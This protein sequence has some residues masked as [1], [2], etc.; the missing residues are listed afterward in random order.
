MLIL[1]SPA[2]SLDYETFVK[3]AES[4]LPH[5][6]KETQELVL[7]LKKLKSADLEKMMGISKKLAELNFERFQK[8]SPKFDLKNSKQAL[9]VFNGDVY[10]PI[11]K[12][13]FKKADFDF[14]QKHLRILSGLYGILKPLD[15]MQAYRLEM[16]TD[17]R[18]TSLEKNLK[19]KNLYQFWGDK[20]SDF[21][22]SE[23]KEN[24]EKYIINLASEEYFSA[25]NPKKIS[26]KIINIIFKEKKAGVYKIIGINAKRARGLMVNFIIENK[27]D[28][29][30]KLKKFNLENYIFE[31]SMSDEFNFTFVR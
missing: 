30:E 16:A 24:H 25:I 20:I 29:V 6:A 11:K 5:F 1:I 9:L 17:F 28:D 13:K 23:V 27:I 3:C 15:L 8:F 10:E 18:K 21:I 4:T 14:A 22:N 7:G 31:K 26:A 2:K 12:D 19:I